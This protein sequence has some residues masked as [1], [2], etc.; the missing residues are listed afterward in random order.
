MDGSCK[1]LYFSRMVHMAT[2][3]GWSFQLVSIPLSHHLAGERFVHAPQWSSDLH[4]IHTI[5]GHGVLHVGRQRYET[6][7]DVVL[8]VPI[9]AYCHWEKTSETPWSMI[10][11]HARLFEAGMN[12]L[13][14]QNLLPIRFRPKGMADI[15]AGL[16]QWRADWATSD[17]G[18]RAMGAAGV[19]G[20]VGGY[21]TQHGR[22]AAA[23]PACPVMSRTRQILQEQASVA[24]DAKTIAREAGLSVSQLNRRFRASFG[25]SPKTYWQH[26]RLDLAQS[27]LTGT[28]S[29]IS[30]ISETLGFSDINYFSRWFRRQSGMAPSQFR[31]QHRVM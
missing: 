24:F 26:H 3:N 31:R 22:D 17:P 5:V 15:H 16:E 29:S 2:P 25:E 4:L 10:N 11:I 20:L 7:P 12:P 13:H 6:T 27:M 8:A 23:P 30:R 9:F 14:E 21:L 19:L 18:R 28:P 1:Y